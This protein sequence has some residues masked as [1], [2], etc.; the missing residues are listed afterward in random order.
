M[1]RTRT[2][3]EKDVIARLADAGED[4]LRRMVDLPRRTVV[5]AR[6]DIGE[7]L[8]DVATKLRAVDPLARRVAELEKRLESLE[9][10]KK[11]TT[12]R[13]ISTHARPSTARKV[14]T[15]AAVVEPEQAEPDRDRVDDA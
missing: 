15:A 12:A 7:R 6:D 13:R 10:P 8:H 11:R 2:P 4:A 9:K 1:A 14:G 5:R 3:Q